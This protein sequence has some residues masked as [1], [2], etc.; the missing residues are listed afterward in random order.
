MLLLMYSYETRQKHPQALN[1]PLLGVHQMFFTTQDQNNLF[2]VFDTTAAEVKKVI[3][4]CPSIDVTH[5]V[6]SDPYNL[7]TLWCVHNTLVNSDLLPNE[8]SQ[9]AMVFMKMLHYKFFTSFVNH[10]Y[11]HG[12]NENVMRAVVNDLTKKY[13]IVEYG[14]WKAT[15][16]ARCADFLDDK[17]IHRRTLLEFDD[18]KQVLY[19]LSDTQTRI[20]NKIKNINELYYDAKKRGDSINVHSLNTELDGEKLMKDTVSTYDSMITNISGEVLNINQWVDNRY[21]KIINAMFPN[22][23]QNLMRQLL[24]SFANRAATQVRSGKLDLEEKKDGTT[25]YIGSRVLIKFVLQ[26]TYRA[27]V[28]AKINMK[29]KNDILIKTKN[30]YSASRISDVDITDV[31]DSVNLAIE[32]CLNIQRDATKASLRIAFICYIMLKSFEYL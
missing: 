27:C 24:T 8:K 32:E 10:S 31:K 20:R 11:P 28:H 7:F 22:V 15:I 3:K 21:I 18:D 16:E 25:R 12:A 19:M 30:I 29:S 23:T 5:N 17:S 26:K 1:S 2:D 6:A 4:H 9:L 14:T 13:D